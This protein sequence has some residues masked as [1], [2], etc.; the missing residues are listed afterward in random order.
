MERGDRELPGV[1]GFRPL[2][3]DDLQLLHDWLGREHVRAWWGDRGTLDETVAEYLP[4]LEGADPT[5]LFA[6]VVEGRDAG[7][8][9]TYLVHDYPDWAALID[10]GDEAAGLDIFLAD[11][12]LL[13]RGLGTEV[14]RHFVGTVVFARAT[15]RACV[16]DPDVRNL[17]SVR[18]FE[19][20]GFSA[21][22]TF[23]DPE[24]GELHLLM[25]L[26]RPSSEQARGERWEC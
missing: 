12:K 1:F 19:K 13:G 21:V 9:Q 26:D 18:A 4:S 2:V 3:S 23:L 15:T 8:I 16:A 6:I 24:D 11:E 14:I 17:A 25:K 20:A 5:D 7:L 10:A 22:K